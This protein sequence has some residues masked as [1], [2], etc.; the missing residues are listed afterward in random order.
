MALS[1][2]ARDHNVDPEQFCLLLAGQAPPN[3][4]AVLSQIQWVDYS[5]TKMRYDKEFQKQRALRVYRRK[6]RYK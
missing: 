5:T 3:G 4:D 1:Q 2:E 6:N